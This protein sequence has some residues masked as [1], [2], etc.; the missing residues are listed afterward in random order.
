MEEILHHQGCIRPC[1]EWDKLYLS[2]G[3]GF[4]PSTVC[5]D[6]SFGDVAI[7]WVGHLSVGQSHLK[8]RHLTM[9]DGMSEFR[10]VEVF[11]R[12]TENNYL[13]S[14]WLFQRFVYFSHIKF[15]KYKTM[16]SMLPCCSNG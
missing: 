11:L 10:S 12:L 16:T 9:T 8:G 14:T 2:T 5:A 15:Q 6:D 7:H 1:K 4:L 3:A 13:E